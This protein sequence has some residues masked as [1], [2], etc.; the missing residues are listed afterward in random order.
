MGGGKR[1]MLPAGMW[2]V[3]GN[4]DAWEFLQNLFQALFLEY[5]SEEDQGLKFPGNS[6]LFASTNS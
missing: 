5:E 1:E 3:P 2:V 4:S 6:V